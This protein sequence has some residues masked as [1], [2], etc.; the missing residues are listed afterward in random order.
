MWRGVA[1]CG[2]QDVFILQMHG[3]K[4]W[5]LY[6][7][8]VA[9]PLDSQVVPSP[10]P[11]ACLPA[12]VAVRGLQARGKSGDVLQPTELGTPRSVVLTPGRILPHAVALEHA[13]A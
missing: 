3:S 9:L 4:L 5:H 7:P 12:D 13:W 6:A 1:W 2:V 8:P 10:M 11:A